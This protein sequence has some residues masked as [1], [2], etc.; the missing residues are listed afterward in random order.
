MV[1]V[2]ITMEGIFTNYAVFQLLLD[3]AWTPAP[4]DLKDWV[5]KFQRGRYGFENE[6]LAAAWQKMAETVYN[7]PRGSRSSERPLYPL[8]QRPRLGSVR[9]G[10]RNFKKKFC[11]I[12]EK[13]L[14]FLVYLSTGGFV[15]NLAK[16]YRCGV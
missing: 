12:Y 8:T 4:L 5:K 7:L 9:P 11:K 1:G 14:H 16:F 13:N 15:Q 3:R 2:G 10:V 6:D